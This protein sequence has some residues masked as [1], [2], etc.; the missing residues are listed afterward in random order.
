M[1]L[2]WTPFP[3]HA[4]ARLGQDGW[5]LADYLLRDGEGP[6]PLHQDRDHARR[7]AALRALIESAFDP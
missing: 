1:G 7:H 5:P 2:T 4:F 6:A 3:P